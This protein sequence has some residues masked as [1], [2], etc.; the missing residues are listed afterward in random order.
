VKAAKLDEVN[1]EAQSAFTGRSS[2]KETEDVK[3]Y[4]N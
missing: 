1:S 4:L 3:A 2:I